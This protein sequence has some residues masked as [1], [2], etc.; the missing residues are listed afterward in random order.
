MDPGV[1]TFLLPAS[2]HSVAE[3]EYCTFLIVSS[4]FS[5]GLFLQLL[6]CKFLLEVT[7]LLVKKSTDELFSEGRKIVPR[8]SAYSMYAE[9]DMRGGS[10]PHSN[11]YEQSLLYL[12][13]CI[14]SRSGILSYS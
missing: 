3:F 11:R 12:S 8:K 6:K 1:R 9:G 2:R 10:A 14:L 13:Q 4:H 7:L 5:K